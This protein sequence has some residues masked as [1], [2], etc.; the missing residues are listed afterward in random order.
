MKH[1]RNLFISHKSRSRKLRRRKN[2]HHR[3]FLHIPPIITIRSAKESNLTVRIL[4][5]EGEIRARREREIVRFKDLSGERGGGDENVLQSAEA[6]VEERTVL[7]GDVE[8]GFVSRRKEEV[9]VADERKRRR[10]WR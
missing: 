2:L 4:L 5:A 6:D 8:E 10:R 9:E 1:T 3:Q 7:G